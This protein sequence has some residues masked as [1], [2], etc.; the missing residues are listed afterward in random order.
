MQ[1]RRSRHE[2]PAH[3]SPKQRLSAKAYVREE[4]ECLRLCQEN[5]GLPG[6][7][8]PARPLYGDNLRSAVPVDVPVKLARAPA[9]ACRRPSSRARQMLAKLRCPVEAS[10]RAR[11]VQGRTSSQSGP[12]TFRHERPRVTR[13]AGHCAMH[14]VQPVPIAFVNSAYSIGDPRRRLRNRLHSLTGFTAEYDP[15]ESEAA[16][17]S[18]A[19]WVG[20]DGSGSS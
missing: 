11:Q 17:F 3:S 9:S 20:G 6:P 15:G 1:V 14:A 5:V 19:Y 8:A 10:S 7:R 2:R 18:R 12:P 16:R 13:A 4:C